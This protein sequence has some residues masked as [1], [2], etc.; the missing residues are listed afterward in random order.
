MGGQGPPRIRPTWRER[1]AGAGPSRKNRSS[2]PASANQ[3]AEVPA[4]SFE[5]SAYCSAELSLGVVQPGRGRCR[6][7]GDVYPW[8]PPPPPPPPRKRCCCAALLC[9]ELCDIMPYCA[10]TSGQRHAAAQCTHVRE[11]TSQRLQQ[12]GRSVGLLGGPPAPACP[13]PAACSLR[14]GVKRCGS[15]EY[16]RA[17]PLPVGNQVRDSAIEGSCAA[18][19]IVKHI[20]CGVHAAQK[21]VTAEHQ[22]PGHLNMQSFRPADWHQCSCT[23]G[24][25]FIAVLHSTNVGLP[26]CTGGT[27]HSRRRHTLRQKK[28]PWASFGSFPRAS[29]DHPERLASTVAAPENMPGSAAGSAR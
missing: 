12:R 20:L 25:G 18:G 14:K 3:W 7:W 26:G 21:A 13:A 2:T 23:T 19:G 28:F 10:C 4:R 24:K 5:M 22:H 29:D 8:C 15:P 16:T 17:Q 6:E 27:A 1:S 9:D 11:N